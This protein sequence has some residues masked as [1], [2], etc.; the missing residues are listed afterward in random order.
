[1]VQ[2]AKEMVGSLAAV[3][4][5]VLLGRACLPAGY[6]RSRTEHLDIQVGKVLIRYN[7]EVAGRQ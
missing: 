3:D 1:M 2:S 5:G 7:K 4:E 6:V